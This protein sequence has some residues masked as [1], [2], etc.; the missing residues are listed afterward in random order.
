MQ[1]VAHLVW[2]SPSFLKDHRFPPRDTTEGTK[3]N[4]EPPFPQ[5]LLFFLD[6][7]VSSSLSLE[8]RAGSSA[9]LG[10]GGC[11]GAHWL[12]VSLRAPEPELRSLSLQ[13]PCCLPLGGSKW[14]I[15]ACGGLMLPGKQSLQ[16]PFVLGEFIGQCIDSAFYSKT[17]CLYQQSH[18][19]HRPSPSREGI[20]G[21]LSGM[22]WWSCVCSASQEEEIW[23][24]VPELWDELH[25][26]QQA[27][28]T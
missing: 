20:P 26:S 28:P 15:L 8:E 10:C 23:V 5:M 4:S 22:S 9:E 19:S 21:S 18:L 12:K 3:R 11:T 13:N 16:H 27:V 6:E 14:K 1:D 25:S 2:K 7:E 17:L 24:A